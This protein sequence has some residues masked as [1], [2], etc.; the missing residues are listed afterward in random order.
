LS[1]AS[2]FGQ[3]TETFE[4]ETNN[5]TSF[6][7][8]GQNFTITSQTANQTFLITGDYP[9]TG[10]NGTAPDNKYIDNTG[11]AAYETVQFTIATTNQD[12]FR[13]K[14]M[15]LFLAQTDLTSGNG[16]C[17]I[18]GKRKGKT[19]FT[20]SAPT[21]FNSS[22]A[23]NGFTF[24]DLASYGG[25]NNSNE[26]VDQFMITTSGTFEYVSLDAL[27]W[28]KIQKISTT[29]SIKPFATCAG[30]ASVAQGFELSGANLTA[31]I[32]VSA[33]VGFE[34][35][36][37]LGTGYAAT[38]TLKQIA[39]LV[40]NTTVYTRLSATA[41]GTPAGNI[42][43]T[44]A[45]ATTNTIAVSGIV[46]AL[47][48]PYQVN[49]GGVYCAG[50][51]GLEIGLS[52]SDS[53]I[54]Y[55]L[56]K[57][58]V[59]IGSAVIGTKSAISFGFIT[60]SGTYT[61]VATNK[62]TA[63]I[64]AMTGNTQ[65]SELENPIVVSSQV[66]VSCKGDSSGSATVTVSGAST[67]YSFY[68][69]PKG[70]AAAI[71]TNLKA[72]KYICTVT[73]DNKCYTKANFTITEPTNALLGDTTATSCGMFGWKGTVYTE[74]GN[75]SKI[76]TSS[77]GCDS[78][79]TLHLTLNETSVINLYEEGCNSVLFN[80]VT[81]TQD[82]LLTFVER[83]EHGCDSTTYV[84]IAVRNFMP[85]TTVTTIGDI[86]ISNEPTS[87]VVYIWKDC[88]SGEFVSGAIEGDS[89]FMAEKSGEYK[90]FIIEPYKGGCADSSQC[91]QVIITATQELEAAMEMSIYPNPSNGIF[92]LESKIEAG[93][94]RIYN[95]LGVELLSD[96]VLRK[97]QNI[98]LSTQP[99]GVYI[100]QVISENGIK[101]VS[102]IKN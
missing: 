83:N 101:E 26:V 21:N 72:G 38:L 14:S 69:S 52:S 6:S 40:A 32:L 80:D 35:S 2:S 42:S 64:S 53:A 19:I 46:N 50:T 48:S 81:Y 87:G 82:T 1:F 33:P 8:N 65:L 11:S 56:Q 27:K 76:L 60:G 67:P 61:V 86:L 45:G 66:N 34:L 18:T 74:S 41:T 84:E 99:S 89:S 73:S 5:A 96:A 49:G 31:D 51:G 75:Y 91:V 92:T 57:S 29:S 70:G 23:N 68:W 63:C 77:M 15:Y 47:P 54:S 12:S 25:V 44:T 102:I 95:N 4:T 85:N 17:T 20:V 88:N 37:S 90:V 36:T 3:T 97:S 100:M 59:S 94:F 24:V 79:V 30:M 55:Q 93:N 43:C 16:N 98:D 78:T 62:T 28:Q 71:A 39:G 10:W 9:S 58:N 13:L 22:V 7:D